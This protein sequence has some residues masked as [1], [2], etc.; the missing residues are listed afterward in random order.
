[1]VTRIYTRTGDH[2][3]TSLFRGGR[4]RK[5]NPR[6]EAY[7]TVDELN[8][9]LGVAHGQAGSVAPIASKLPFI[10]AQLL[11]LGAELAT[12]PG[13]TPRPAGLSEDDVTI[14]EKLI[15]EADAEL[16]PLRTFVLPAGVP[17]A[18]TLHLARTICRRAERRVVALCE[19]EPE[20]AALSVKLLNRLSDLLFVWARL[21]NHRAGCA[22]QPWRPRTA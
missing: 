2:G 19:L 4:V 15:D 5:D 14:L 3:E 7:G 22:E 20:T 9:A 1:M 8:A 18:T 11:E 10:Q 17:L 12:P 13:V 16:P 6:V 21:A